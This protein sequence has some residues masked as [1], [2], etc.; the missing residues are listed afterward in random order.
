MN[1]PLYFDTNA[2][3]P[4]PPVVQKAMKEALEAGFGNPSSAHASGRAARAAV[5]GARVRVAAHLGCEAE[6]V[7]FTSGA[8]EAHNALFHSL[9]KGRFKDRNHIATTTVEHDSVIKPVR[10]LEAQGAIAHWLKVSPQ[11]EIDSAQLSAILSDKLLFASVML[12]NNETGMVFPIQSIAAA[13]KKTGAFFHTDAACVIGKQPVSFKELG[14]DYL[15]LSGHKF[16]GPKGV[17]ALIVRR[18]AP[19]EPYLE[20][21]S[22]ERGLR[23]GTVNVEGI[24]GLAAGLD[25]ALEGAHAEARRLS[26]LRERLKAGLK[27]I[28]P[29]IEFHEKPGAQLPGT[30]NA[31][32]PQMNSRTLLARLDLEGIAASAGSACHSGALEVS[33]VLLEMG[34]PESEAASSI[35]LSF[36][37]T[38]PDADI[39]RLLAVF[40]KIL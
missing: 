16:Y 38:N 25:Y 11:G 27:Q 37:K 5:D 30:L 40:Q 20:G 18:G 13:V 31:A 28:S 22:Q 39:D 23:A 21:G 19:L 14:V 35:R 29:Q 36:G 1:N 26:D 34:F 6:E 3:T 24:L 4:M 12:A 9:W 17:G 10:S 33:R 8:T 32:F 7:V 2:T 15:S